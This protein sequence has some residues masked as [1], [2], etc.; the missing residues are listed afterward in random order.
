M[1]FPI[2]RMKSTHFQTFK[3][4]YY[5]QKPLPVSALKTTGASLLMDKRIVYG[6]LFIFAL[7]SVHA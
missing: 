7:I 1:L 6:H 3:F 2:N 4:M 5:M